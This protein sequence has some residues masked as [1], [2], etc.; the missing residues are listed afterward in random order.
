M[1]KNFTLLVLAF[2]CVSGLHAQ[3]FPGFRTG[4]YAGVNGVFSNPASI[5]GSPY[6][7]DLNIFSMN[8][9]IGN[10]QASFKLNDLGSFGDDFSDKFFGEDASKTNGLANIS[11]GL[12]SFM[13]N[14]GPKMSFAFSS[15]ARVVANINDMNGKLVKKITSDFENDPDLPYTIA[16]T[17]N[18]LIN[19][20]GWTEFGA[21]LAREIYN[22]GNQKIQGGITVKYLA[23]VA[24]SHLNIGNLNGTMNADI[25]AEDA[26]LSNTTGRLALG[27]SGV[28]FSDFE[29]GD[30]TKFN[31]SGVGADI[32]FVYK[33][34]KAVKDDDEKSKLSS[35]RP[36]YKLRLGFSILDLGKIGFKRDVQRS[37]AYDISITGAE[38]YY[39]SNLD[40]VDL[41]SYKQ[42]FDGQPQYFTP[43]A[44]STTSKYSVSLPTTMQL[45]A[46]YRFGKFFY[47]NG[48]GQFA[49]SSNK[50]TV[51]NSKYYGTFTI[52]PRIERSS[53]GLFVPINSNP[54]TGTNVGAGVRVGPLMLGSGSIISALTGSS[55]QAD[56]FFGFHLG[57]LK[58]KN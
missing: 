5:V 40:D 58:K 7:F 28:N 26:Y 51:Y 8:A 53:Y 6:R 17:D 20:S 3:D 9:S 16:S 14:L 55:Q 32:G 27:F 47:I 46:D 36:D 43:A 38:R 56:L 24:N 1:K 4:N 2:V 34:K 19:I 50:T 22:K 30:I 35:N 41:D 49:L 54:L 45:D 57:L 11:L 23:G 42:K 21:T 33:W 15:R 13:F 39:F 44:G 48:A 37:G 18:M 12:P 10:D 29:G 25:V 31:G 52:T